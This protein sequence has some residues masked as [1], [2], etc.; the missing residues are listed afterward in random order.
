MG[1][2]IYIYIY[3][4]ICPPTKS[5]PKVTPLYTPTSVPGESRN[6]FPYYL[7]WKGTVSTPRLSPSP[8]FGDFSFGHGRCILVLGHIHRP[9]NCDFF[10]FLNWVFSPKSTPV[11]PNKRP[12]ALSVGDA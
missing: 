6:F 12:Q 7:P 4:F 1:K 3:I 9:Y 8:I 5:V 2:T 11:G 10:F